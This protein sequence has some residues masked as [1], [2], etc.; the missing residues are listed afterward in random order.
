MVAVADRLSTYAA[1]L[2]VDW[3]AGRTERAY[4]LTSA[5]DA[6]LPVF[7]AESAEG[8]LAV[9]IAT[10]WEPESDPAAEDARQLMEERLTGGNVR[11]PYVVWVPPA[12][13]VPGEEP[14]ASDFVMRTQLAAAPMQPGTRNEIVLPVKIR[15]AKL[16]DEGGYANVS[17]GLSRFWTQITDRVE[18]T[19]SV[20]GM[21][22]RRA[23]QSEAARNVLFDAIGAR[24]KDLATGEGAEIDASEAWTVQR[25]RAEPLGQTGF[26]IAQAPPRID[27][28]DGTLMRRLVRKRLKA[29]AAALDGIDADV[30]GVGLVAIYEYAEHENVGSFVKS[31]DPGLYARLPLIAA[32]AD[33]EVRPIFQPR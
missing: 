31:L 27:P 21:R 32:I 28:S 12:A 7:A 30:K 8:T 1:A 16:R 6:A 33:G 4:R 24:S 20:N 23:P 25:L 26:A 19:F 2:L 22:I 17:G 15:I 18:G 14:G 11:G 3:Y 13:S 5:T 10:L 29:A 9:A